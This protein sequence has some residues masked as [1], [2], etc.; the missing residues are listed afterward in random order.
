MSN[1]FIENDELRKTE[2]FIDYQDVYCPDQIDSF[3]GYWCP[4]FE[5]SED[6]KILRLTCRSYVRII[7]LTKGG[8]ET[9]IKVK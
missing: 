7:I 3:C 1:F 4:F 6:G 8:E 5:I 2:D 9:S